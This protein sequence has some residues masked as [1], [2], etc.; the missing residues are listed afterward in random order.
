M[1][2]P[3]GKAPPRFPFFL[4][5]LGLSMLPA[6]PGGAAV[7]SSHTLTFQDRVETPDGDGVPSSANCAPHGSA[8]SDLAA[9]V[10]DLLLGPDATK[11][12]WSYPST[13]NPGESFRSALVRRHV[14]R[15]AEGHHRVPV[16]GLLHLTDGRV[17]HIVMGHGAH[18][19]H[20]ISNRELFA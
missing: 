2:A 15:D 19:R 20:K 17:T 9:D 18:F 11:L 13:M 10:Q 4:L 1:V 3:C 8:T 7:R 16:A 14:G 6:A 12:S 5:L